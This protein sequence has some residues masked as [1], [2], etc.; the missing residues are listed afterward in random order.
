MAAPPRTRRD[1]VFK[2]IA[3]PTRREIVA[4]LR[5]SQPTVGELARRFHQSRPAISR[6]LR[7]LRRAG[8]VATHRLGRNRICTL[9]AAPLRAVADWIADVAPVS[10]EPP[11]GSS[12]VV[13]GPGDAG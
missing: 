12:V 13:D 11:R 1:A 8:L 5:H 4:T 7:V 3:D 9:D 2:A 6:H 10:A